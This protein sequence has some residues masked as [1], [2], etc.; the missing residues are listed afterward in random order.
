MKRRLDLVYAL[1]LLLLLIIAIF[2]GNAIVKGILLFLFSGYLFMNTLYRL[3]TLR[4]EKLWRK[5][6]YSLLLLI[7]LLLM[8]AAIVVIAAEFA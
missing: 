8:I 2:I 5:I 4:N 6:Y 7:D 1:I 3:V